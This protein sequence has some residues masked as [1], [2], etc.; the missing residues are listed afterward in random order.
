MLPINGFCDVMKI[1]SSVCVRLCRISCLQSIQILLISNDR[2]IR[3]VLSI[4]FLRSLAI[5]F[6]FSAI[7][8]PAF[9]P[10]HCLATALLNHSVS[11]YPDT[12]A[13]GGATTTVVAPRRFVSLPS[14]PKNVH[15]PPPGELMVVTLRGLAIIQVS[16][17]L[18]YSV[19]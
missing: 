16:D 8:L 3:D 7:R 5:A 4:S 12:W 10:P 15:N 19:T 18:G 14:I 6:Q 2:S 9:F 17:V 11:Q 13:C 1:I